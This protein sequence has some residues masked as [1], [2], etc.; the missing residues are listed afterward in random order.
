MFQWPLR[1]AACAAAL[2][3]APVPV[4]A[5]NIY[6]PPA[7]QQAQA[8]TIGA[9]ALDQLVSPVALYPDTLLAQILAAS[10]YPLDIVQAHR[11]IAQPDNAALTGEALAQAVA[12]QGWDPSVQALVPFAQVLQLM[13]D[14]L[15]WTEQLGEAFLAQPQDV[16]SAVQRLRH[17][18]QEA[19]SLKIAPDQSVVNEGDDI[20]IASA[21]GPDAYVPSYDPQCVYGPDGAA[22][23]AGFDAA[24]EACG[25]A[26]ADALDY[27]PVY[28]PY[29]FFLWGAIDWGHHCIRIDRERYALAQPG[30]PGGR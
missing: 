21:A 24:A 1:A 6:P 20:T 11:W 9:P 27:T 30:R 19:G 15:N 4:L 16:L 2:S 5:Q 7:V 22:V 29:G 8:A 26:S 10:T 3:L 17:R 18:A 23:P 28:L 13:D 25:T 14:H 12:A